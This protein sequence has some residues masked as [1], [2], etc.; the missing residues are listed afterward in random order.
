MPE[1]SSPN[2]PVLVETTGR[3]F[4]PMVRCHY[5]AIEYDDPH[6][7][8][9]LGI[10]GIQMPFLMLGLAGVVLQPMGAERFTTYGLIRGLF[11]SVE[12]GGALVNFEDIWLPDFLFPVSPHVGHVYRVGMKLFYLAFA[13]RDSRF[14]REEFEVY[15]RE[16]QGEISFSEDETRAF[17]S[18]TAEEI[19][20]A[21]NGD[22]K[23]PRLQLRTRRE[24]K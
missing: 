23:N 4:F 19:S 24:L 8:W 14:S 17:G 6:P 20:M 10:A 16:L 2:V 5:L 12:E 18:W 13:Y 7:G 15:C 9:T 21:Q 1:R 22:P 11:E 3:P